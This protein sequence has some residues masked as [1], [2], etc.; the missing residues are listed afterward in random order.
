MLR[1]LHLLQHRARGNKLLEKS[2]P[3][4]ETYIMCVG[5]EIVVDAAQEWSPD[6]TFFLL[7]PS[8]GSLTQT[9]LVPIF[10][11]PPGPLRCSVVLYP[12]LNLDG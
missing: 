1:A 9:L 6:M 3:N 4:N 11:S 7:S 8:A 2:G 10:P 5:E 12:L